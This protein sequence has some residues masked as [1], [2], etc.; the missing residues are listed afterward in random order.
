[1]KI[2]LFI[3]V[4][5]V[6]IFSFAA[7]GE[8]STVKDS[9]DNYSS[10]I[11][12]YRDHPYDEIWGKF[13]DNPNR[14]S[15]NENGDLNCDQVPSFSINPT[16]GFLEVVW[17]KF[18]GTDYEVAYSCFNG[19]EWSSYDVITNNSFNDFDP[20]L[21]FSDDGIIKVTWWSDEPIPQVYYKIRK[22]NGLWS[23][24]LR[25]SDPF[26][27]SR[28][29]SIA[30][31]NHLSFISFEA[32][33]DSNSKNIYVAGGT[34]D[35]DPHPYLINRVFIGSSDFAPNSQPKPHVLDGHIWVD[36]IY[37]EN[38]LCWSEKIGKD[39]TLQRYEAYSG[40]DD[41]QRA[42][43]YIKIKVLNGQ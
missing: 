8:M 34:D 11:F 15:L 22:A 4:I 32:P 17:S 21:A 28:F 1:M 29:P 20:Y 40:P 2:R 33:I 31:L 9:N 18:D 14:V 37:D 7:L 16:T 13:G 38:F 39:W 10:H 5:S 23:L 12:M 36:W 30:A 25:I 42:R 3:L 26:E 19:S 6:L 24:K 43:L 27:T 41:I 35:P